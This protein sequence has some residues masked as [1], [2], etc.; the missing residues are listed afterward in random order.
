MQFANEAASGATRDEPTME[1]INHFSSHQ[2]VGTHENHL[3]PFVSENNMR[4]VSVHMHWVMSAVGAF[5][6]NKQ[7]FAFVPKWN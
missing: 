1:I 6:A 4:D 2:L 3:T 5:D 7:P